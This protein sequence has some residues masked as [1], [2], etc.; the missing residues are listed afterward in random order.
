M[1]GLPTSPQI[2]LLWDAFIAAA[3]VIT[4]AATTTIT[5]TVASASAEARVSYQLFQRSSMRWPLSRARPP[6]IKST[7]SKGHAF[8]IKNTMLRIVARVLIARQHDLCRTGIEAATIPTPVYRAKVD[9]GRRAVAA[10]SAF[11]R[12]AADPRRSPFFPADPRH[13][14]ASARFVVSGR[15]FAGAAVLALPNSR[16]DRASSSRVA[17][18]AS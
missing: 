4:P 17:G 9:Y 11:R 16:L 13:L 12:L 2:N 8:A 18:V 10:G 14:D 1:T 3:S 5:M 15:G 7:L 6:L